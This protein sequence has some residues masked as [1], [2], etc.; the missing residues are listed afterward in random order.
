MA[1]QCYGYINPPVC[2]RAPCSLACK[3]SLPFILLNAYR[4][5][6]QGPSVQRV[7]FFVM[8]CSNAAGLCLWARHTAGRGRDWLRGEATWQRVVAEELWV[9]TDGV[10]RRC[11]SFGVVPRTSGPPACS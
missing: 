1:Y 3:P 10:F 5:A 11:M 7:G 6:W 2:P 8:S 9:F 4:L